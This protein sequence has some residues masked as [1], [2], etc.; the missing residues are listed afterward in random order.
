MSD[1]SAIE[2]TDA[3]W[4]PVTGC[5]KVSAG[6]KN[7]Y[8]ERWAQRFFEIECVVGTS[9]TMNAE[10]VRRPFS[11]VRC[12]GD[13]LDTPLHWRNP[14]RVFVCSMS[15]LFHEA[16]PDEFLDRVF[17][18]MALCPQHTFQ[19]LTKRPDRMHQ[20]LAS[21]DVGARWTLAR[22]LPAIEEITASVA[23]DWTRNGLPNVWLGVS[24]EDQ[25]TADERIPLLLQTPAPLRFVSC[26]PLLEPIDLSEFLPVA[27][28]GGVEM[29]RWPNWVIVGGESGPHVLAR[30]CEVA[31]IRSILRQC[32]AASVP[33]FV[34][35]VG[36]RPDG[37][38]SNSLG[39]RFTRHALKNRKGADPSEWPADLRVREW[40]R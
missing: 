9:A 24:C 1:S 5:T 23:V 39:P 32:R 26:E 19:V 13:R 20:Y 22:G 10:R 18:V 38:W 28:I 4:N 35:Q 12:H 31:W 3:T 14:R 21:H 29:E 15:D 2:W 6:C 17:A 25:T 30:P 8:A 36:S 37:W 27:T 40:P 7:C 11:V 34:K 33:C 16:V